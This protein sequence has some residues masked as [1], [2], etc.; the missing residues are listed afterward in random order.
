MIL[1]CMILLSVMALTFLVLGEA[2]DAGNGTPKRC[3]YDN[4]QRSSDVGR[5]VIFLAYSF[6]S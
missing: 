2:R 4:Y 1:S 3:L 5:K 6:S